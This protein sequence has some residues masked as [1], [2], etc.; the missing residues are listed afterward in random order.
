MSI[1]SPSDSGVS[2]EIA[3]GKLSRNGGKY[4]LATGDLQSDRGEDG[5]WVS[6]WLQPVS[7]GFSRHP[8]SGNSLTATASRVTFLQADAQGVC[9][10]R[11]EVWVLHH[12]RVCRHLSV[13]PDACVKVYGVR[14]PLL[15][16][17][18][19]KGQAQVVR[20]ARQSDLLSHFMVP[21][22]SPFKGIALAQF[23]KN[24]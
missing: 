10:L 1:S 8:P 14:F 15:N 12:C 3:N 22:S 16:F 11:D 13:C 5:G 19:S 24:N 9:T 4:A 7:L 21:W 23:P 20:L 2:E 6:L 17:C 18:G